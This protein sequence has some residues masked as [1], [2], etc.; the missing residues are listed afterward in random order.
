MKMSHIDE[1][2]LHAYLDG[3]VSERQR[4]DVEDHLA[5][6]AECQAKLDVARALT[7][8][9]ADLLSELEPGPVQAP[10][11]REIEERAAA[12]R[13]AAPRRI[14]L[15]PGVAW[16]ASI[17]LAFAIGWAA[18]SYWF[19]VP[20]LDIASRE[21]A[22]GALEADR[23]ETPERRQGRGAEPAEPQPASQIARDLRLTEAE[24][25][26]A[27]TP[28]P[29]TRTAEGETQ[30]AGQ[31]PV[32]DEMP[33]AAEREDRFAEANARKRKGEPAEE[34]SP[35]EAPAAVAAIEVAGVER[36]ERLAD[37]PADQ[38][39]ARGV[40][41]PRALAQPTVA[42][43]AAPEGQFVPVQPEEAQVWMGAELRT[44]PDLHLKRVEVG[45]GAAVEHAESRLPA[46]RL[47]YEDAAGHEI[48]LIQQWL[49]NL[50]ADLDQLE[51]ALIVEPSTARAYRWLDGEGYLL[52]LYGD[53]SGD[54][55]RALADRVR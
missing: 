17:A 44:L 31:V 35:E 28:L 33:P 19:A 27:Q 25:S 42:A 1:G 14:R 22:V 20:P 36:E 49:G 23:Q 39:A 43:G 37:A 2:T 41:P 47:L 48:V 18:R 50:R 21:R 38:T 32:T 16:A 30:V 10:S 40:Q 52:I 29:T 13:R 53:V 9:A 54:S 34:P 4:I 6:C 5:V 24:E 45:P 8:R 7:G 12:R 51:P 11:W 3:E 26:P 46:I 55:L 15:R